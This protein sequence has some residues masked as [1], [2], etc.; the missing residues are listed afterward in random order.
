MKCVSESP[1]PEGVRFRGVAAVDT[2][3]AV[4]CVDDDNH[5][6]IFKL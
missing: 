3:C 1:R 5:S 6:E 2:H 4:Q